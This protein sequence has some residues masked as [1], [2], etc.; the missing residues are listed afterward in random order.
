[1]ILYI[2]KQRVNNEYRITVRIINIYRPD[3]IYK[4]TNAIL[5]QESNRLFSRDSKKS[6]LY[7]KQ[8]YG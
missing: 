3:S 4:L 2:F 5:F 7:Y 8:C 6:K 1:M